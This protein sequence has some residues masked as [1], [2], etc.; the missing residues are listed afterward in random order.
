MELHIRQQLIS[1]FEDWAGEQ[2]TAIQPLPSSGSHRSYYRIQSANKHAIGAYNPDRH[3]NR[4]FLEFSQHFRSAGL[5]VPEIYR[6]NETECIYLLEDLGD[7]TLLSYINQH[8]Q[9]KELTDDIINIYKIVV[10]N[11]PNFQIKAGRN[12]NF[13]FCYPRQQFDKQS[14]MWD[15]N[16]FKYCF[17]KPMRIAFNEQLL[18]D[19]FQTLTDYL[20]QTETDYFMYRD[21]QSRNILLKD[22]VLFYIDYQGGRKGALQ[23][24]LASL[25]YDAK[26]EIPD[27]VREMLITEYL[28]TVAK[29]AK[30][31]RK[32]FFKYFQGY[33]LLR[34][35]QAMGAYGFRGLYEKKET[36]IQS[37]PRALINLSTL[38]N[39]VILP[40]KIPSLW[41]ALEDLAQSRLPEQS[42]VEPEILT[43][44]I[45]SFS[46]R[47]GIPADPSK[48]GGGFVFDCRAIH[49]PG[50]YESF[51]TLTGKDEA[52]GKFLEK[53]AG[54]QKFL[55]PVFSII[56]QT[57]ET[58]LQRKFTKL[59]VS[60]G[61][62]GGRHRSVY[63][64]GA[65]ADHLRS[66][67]A[68]LQL[69]INHLELE[70]Q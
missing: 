62:T 57:V 17:L 46:Y 28:D 45:N 15:L 60:F 20:L 64:A 14:M 8:R 54:I 69:R 25:L 5:N 68:T 18:E 1:L 22:G 39:T 16:Y 26:A 35:M 49:N 58:Y 41:Q 7:T 33:V 51:A 11:L 56:D 29:Y 50:R 21:F 34:I 3:E 10:K 53:E 23:Y 55:K 32:T 67:Y 24:D 61:C 6:E 9:D 63:C 65:L 36:F 4:A 59:T 52:V 48:H 43:V 42:P 47:R 66:K 38:L 31:Q 70:M 44:T 13:A 30:I 19:D 2:I 12:L 40:I 37:I 27:S